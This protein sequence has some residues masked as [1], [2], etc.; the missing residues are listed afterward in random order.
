MPPAAGQVHQ[1][2]HRRAEQQR[3]D[4][5]EIALIALEYLREWRRLKARELGI[6]AFIIMHDTSLDELCRVKPTSLTTIRQV[7][8]FGQRKTELYGEAILDAL[9]KFRSGARTVETLAKT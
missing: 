1:A 4:L 6:A 9:A 2:D 8:G 3:V 7:S 5:V